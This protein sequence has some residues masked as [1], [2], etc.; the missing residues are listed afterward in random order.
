MNASLRIV[1][2]DDEPDMREYLQKLLPRLGHQVVGAADDGRTLIELCRTQRP[3]LVVTDIK[4]PNVDGIDAAEQIYRER[5][6]PIL[7]VSAYHDAE[8]IARAE[9][10]HVLGYLVKPINPAELGLAIVQAVH[11]FEQLQRC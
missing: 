5:P 1:V 4:M 8:L 9:A 3:D 10:D 6:V 7:L 11:R 2:A